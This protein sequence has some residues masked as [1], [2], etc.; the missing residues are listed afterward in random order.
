MTTQPFQSLTSDDLIEKIDN[1]LETMCFVMAD[2]IEPEDVAEEPSVNAWIR[3]GNEA[4]SGV[5]HLSATPGFVQEAASGL[6]G[7]DPEDIQTDGE[8]LETLLELANVIGGEVVSLL[9]GED[10]FFEMGLPSADSLE[11]ESP[12]ETAAALFD[13][14]GEA[15][16]VEVQRIGGVA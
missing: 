3:Y 14:M 12:R 5:V 1:V 13:S 8:A 4:E 15:F 10:V 16:R 6:L 9:G 7:V 2:P 11:L